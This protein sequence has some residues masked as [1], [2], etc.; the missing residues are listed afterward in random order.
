[1]VYALPLLVIVTSYMLILVQITRNMR[2]VTGSPPEI[3]HVTRDGAVRTRLIVRSSAPWRL[4]KAKMRTL[5]MTLVIVSVF[6]ICWTPYFFI[7]SLHWFHK[8]WTQE[9]LD[10]KVQ[11]AL[12]IFAVSNSCFD[13]AIYGMFTATFRREASKWAEYMYKQCFRSKV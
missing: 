1:M 12:F 6:I 8:D 4:C 7:L 13:P 10:H 2:N 3:V 5:K 11:R 9:K